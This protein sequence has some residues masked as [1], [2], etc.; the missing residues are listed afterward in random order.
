MLWAT[1]SLQSQYKKAIFSSLYKFSA[2]FSFLINYVPH[3]VFSVDIASLYM[4]WISSLAFSKSSFT[5]SVLNRLLVSLFYTFELL[6]SWSVFAI[7]DNSQ[8]PFHL[9]FLSTKSSFF[10]F[11]QFWI[12]STLMLEFIFLWHFFLKLLDWHL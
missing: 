7:E 12:K 10:T 8:T 1:S 11:S 5:V 4:V 9:Y 2:F 3:L 6:L